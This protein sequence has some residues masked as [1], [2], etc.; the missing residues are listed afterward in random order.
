VFWPNSPRAID[1]YRARAIS[2]ALPPFVTVV[3]VFVDQELDYVRGVAK[4][5]RLGAV[6]LHGSEPLAFCRDV[7]Y[8]V[9]K[10]VAVGPD[11][12]MNRLDPISRDVTVLL[13]VHDPVRRGGTG[14][15]IDWQIAANV[16]RRR[17]V[18]LSGGLNPENVGAAIRA[19][20]PYGIDVS[21]GVEQS[22]GIKDADRMRRLFAAIGSCGV[23]GRSLERLEGR[24]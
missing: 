14:R 8:R 6:Q 7:G 23:G 10:S 3:G 24:T 9:I 12:E 4:L 13:D 2:L 5:V 17:P 22:P 21:S 16:A 19:V 11:F 1:P 20:N 15:T 18:I